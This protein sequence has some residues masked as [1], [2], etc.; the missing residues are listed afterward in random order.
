M[1]KLIENKVSIYDAFKNSGGCF[2]IARWK[3]STQCEEYDV[4]MSGNI[5]DEA[6]RTLSASLASGVRFW[7]RDRPGFDFSLDNLEN[8]VLE[9]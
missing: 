5:S 4:S 2:C 7:N 3:K 1:K 8:S 9:S 6:R